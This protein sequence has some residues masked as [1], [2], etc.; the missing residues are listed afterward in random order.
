MAVNKIKAVVTFCTVLSTVPRNSLRNKVSLLLISIPFLCQ[1]E[2]E[3]HNVAVIYLTTQLFWSV[4][5]HAD[6]SIFLKNRVWQGAQ[7]ST[8]KPWADFCQLC[9]HSAC[10]LMCLVPHLFH[11]ICKEGPE[12]TTEQRMLKTHLHTHISC[13]LY[14][15][16]SAQS[17]YF[18]HCANR[19][20][21]DKVNTPVDTEA[22]TATTI[23]LLCRP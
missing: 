6:Q 4:C 5:L 9:S 3:S 13:V 8:A 14:L 18:N 17:E 22:A 23:G 7:E 2:N 20:R 21:L 15:P 16:Y 10:V 1:S 12:Q 11:I 19:E